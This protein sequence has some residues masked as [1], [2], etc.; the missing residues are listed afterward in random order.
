MDYKESYIELLETNK[1]LDKELDSLRSKNLEKSEIVSQTIMRIFHSASYL[2]AISKL[3]S[4]QYV[5]VNEAF[6]KTLGYSKEEIIGHTSDDIQIF[7]DFE[8]SNKYIKLI[9]KLRSIKGYP[10]TLK[11]KTGEEK[12]YYFSA[13]TI[14]L[15]NEI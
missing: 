7:S 3:D 1:K 5:D 2:M 15:E 8:E 10:V 6:Y 14:Q 11:T 12:P 4:G 9:S 13:D